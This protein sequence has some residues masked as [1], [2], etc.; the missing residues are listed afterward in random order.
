MYKDVIYSQ[1]TDF[2]QKGNGVDPF[3]SMWV[4]LQNS[5]RTE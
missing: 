1:N 5:T 4:C 3:L 2:R